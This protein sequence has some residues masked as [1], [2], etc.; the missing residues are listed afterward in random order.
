MEKENKQP[1]QPEEVID[2]Q[3][4]IDRGF[5][6]MEM[7]CRSRCFQSPFGKNVVVQEIEKKE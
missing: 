3:E 2:E 1:E 6:E 5:T 7:L 4:K